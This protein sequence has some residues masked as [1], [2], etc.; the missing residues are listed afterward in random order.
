MENENENDVTKRAQQE[1]EHV[2]HSFMSDAD[3]DRG[4][5]AT[6]NSAE[7]YNVAEE[8]DLDDV[9]HQPLA[10]DEGGSLPDSEQLS[11]DED[12]EFEP[13]LRNK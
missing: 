8:Q 13:D 7:G 9:V 10:D 5:A 6:P 12:D 4:N 1:N 3:A 11:L 2:A